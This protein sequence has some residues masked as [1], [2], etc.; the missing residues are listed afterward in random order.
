MAASNDPWFLRGDVI[1]TF[2]L[3]MLIIAF[4]F[5]VNRLIMKD[6]AKDTHEKFVIYVLNTFKHQK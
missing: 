1:L 5:K 4:T 3:Y 2:W 6:L